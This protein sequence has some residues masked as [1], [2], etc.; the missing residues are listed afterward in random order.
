MSSVSSAFSL[1]PPRGVTS[2]VLRPQAT[3]S[4]NAWGVVETMHDDINNE[5]SEQI[6]NALP[7]SIVEV[8]H[9][10]RSEFLCIQV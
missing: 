1:P 8:Y 5:I 2:V 9:M 3:S 10:L 4:F 7:H 6:R